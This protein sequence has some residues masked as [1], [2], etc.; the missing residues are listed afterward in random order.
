LP[1]I[2]DLMKLVVLNADDF[3]L[4]PAINAAV[5]RA[6][7]DGL[8][9]SASLVIGA[10]HA[11]EAVEFARRHPGLGVGIHLVLVDELPKDSPWRVPSLACANGSLSTGPLAL[12]VALSFSRA[13]ERAV[14]SEVRAQIE[15]FLATGLKPTHLDAHMH[16]HLHPRAL[17]I[18]ANMAGEYRICYV[19]APV[20]PLRCAGIKGLARWGIF[21]AGGRYARRRLRRLG[22]DTADRCIGVVGP[23]QLTEPLLSRCL[24]ELPDGLTEVFFH[25]A[26]E[27]SPQLARRQPGFRHAEELQALLSPQLRQIID[28]HDIRL[29]NFRELSEGHRPTGC[30]FDITKTIN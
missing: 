19:R 4:D 20:E 28:S 21:A 13:A 29:T 8:L 5:A 9:T 18:V 14:A 6:H 23:G 30:H 17:R 7:T 3:G 11:A 12:S 25:P 27:T 15:R 24:S 10:A 16:A 26:T 1:A 2:L 22:V